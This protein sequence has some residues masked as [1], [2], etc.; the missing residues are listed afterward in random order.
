ARLL[1][2]RLRLRAHCIG[3]LLR[4]VAAIRRALRKHPL[5]DLCI[6]I[7]ALRLIDRRLVRVDAEPRK[8]FENRV[9][10][11]LRRALAVGVLDAQEVGAAVVASIEPGV[12]RRADAADVEVAGGARGEA[13]ADC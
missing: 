12:E 7:E 4:A 5:D 13:G 1:A 3:L 10:R 8:A 6:T 9:D 11:G 2:P